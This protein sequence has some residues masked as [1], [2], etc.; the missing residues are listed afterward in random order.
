ME[1]IMAKTKKV[2]NRPIK[3][4]LKSKRIVW[5]EEHPIR[6]SFLKIL[7]ENSK[8][9][10]FYPEVNPYVEAYR[11]RDNTWAL[12]CDG[13]HGHGDPWM[14]L[15]EGPQRAVVIDTA[16]GVGDLI[17]LARKL[18]N[19]KEV[20]AANTHH[21]TDH[22][23]GNAQFD[24][25]YCHED[26]EFMLRR[27]MRPD[28]WDVLLDENG[29]PKAAEFDVND[30]IKY[31]DYELITVKSNECIDLGDGYL[32]ECVPLR[33]HT[34]GMCGWLDKQTGCLFSGDLTN[35]MGALD[36]EEPHPENCTVERLQLD[37]SEIC[38]RLDEISGVFPGHGMIDQ[39]PIMLQYELDTLNMVLA[40]PENY[41]KVRKMVRAGGAVDS[42]TKNIYQGTAVRYTPNNVYMAQQ[43]RK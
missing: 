12:Y 35:M 16:F 8:L 42:C 39:T 13:I 7:R 38:K 25:V 15:V 18:V 40:N 22:A 1:V 37:M 11:V 29:K 33:G 28:L 30:I 19:G 31:K 36:P 26:E 21:H 14:Y 32:L 27:N 9:K 5:E 43:R 6:W 10:E 24:K 23:Y 17:G 2:T 3:S 20:V 4:D 41:D 34:P